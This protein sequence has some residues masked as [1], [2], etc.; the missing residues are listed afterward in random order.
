MSGRVRC[1]RPVSRPCLVGSLGSSRKACLARMADGRRAIARLETGSLRPQW[2][3]EWLTAPPFSPS[4]APEQQEFQALLSENNWALLEKLL[5]WFQAQ[6][7]IPSPLVLQN[8]YSAVEELDRVRMADL[9]GWASDFESWGRL[10]DWLLPL[11]PSLPPRLF[12]V[13]EVFG[14]WQNTFAEFRNDRSAKIVEVASGWLVD[15]EIS[16][17]S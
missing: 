11:A 8:A 2:R 3:R 7:T 17:V 12:P 10:L 9:V 13:L 16:R 5:V 6:H 15:L 14:V 4:F 1:W